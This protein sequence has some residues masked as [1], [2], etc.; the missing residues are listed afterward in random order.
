MRHWILGNGSSLNKTPLDLL[1]NEITWGIN[2]PPVP[3]TFYF[4]QDVNEKDA[5]WKEAIKSNLNC[6]RVYLWDG[7]KEYF[8]NEN[9]TWVP[10]CD[11]KKERHHSYPADHVDKR[12]TSWHLPEVCTAFGS[13][14][15]VLQLAVLNGA[16]EIYLVGC[17]LFTGKN[18]HYDS[19]YPAFA[20]WRVRNEIEAYLHTVS[21]MSSPVPIFNATIGGSLEVYPRVDIFEILERK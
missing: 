5:T 16:T 14:Y 3:T 21:A 10:H 15:P 9:I 19:N 6:K 2:R 18:D 12:A 11:K 1:N 13:M 17:D 20:D 8:K 4:C 7:F